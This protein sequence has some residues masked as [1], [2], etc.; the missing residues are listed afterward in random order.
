MVR[1]MGATK[2]GT[3]VLH[4]RSRS[5][6]ASKKPTKANQGINDHYDDESFPPPQAE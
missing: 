5:Q 2:K 1:M 3:L 4:N 6:L